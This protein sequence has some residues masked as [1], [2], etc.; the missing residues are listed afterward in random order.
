MLF[1]VAT[2]SGKPENPRKTSFFKISPG[3]SLKLYT[4]CGNVPGKPRKKYTLRIA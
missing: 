3:K 2:V 4:F 1:R